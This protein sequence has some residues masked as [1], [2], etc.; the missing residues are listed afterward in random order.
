MSKL[1]DK[2]AAGLAMKIYTDSRGVVT[3]QILKL[4]TNWST[5]SPG[6]FITGKEPRQTLDGSLGGPQ[7]VWTFWRK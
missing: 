6:C 2:I 7:L 1:K 4:G 3:P 5:S